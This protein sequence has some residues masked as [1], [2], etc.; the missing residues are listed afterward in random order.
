MPLKARHTAAPLLVR[1]ARIRGVV[2][3]IIDHCDTARLSACLI[4][5][6]PRRKAVQRLRINVASRRVTADTD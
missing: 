3:V 5:T 1:V 4:E 2:P 6:A